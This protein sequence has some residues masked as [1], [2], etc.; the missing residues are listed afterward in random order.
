MVLDVAHRQVNQL[1][2]PG[3][4]FVQHRDERPIT[5]IPT[6]IFERVDVLSGQ[7]LLRQRP[8]LVRRRRRDPLDR[9]RI[10]I[11]RVIEPL[12]ELFDDL[13]IVRLRNLRENP[14]VNPLEEILV[15]VPP[16]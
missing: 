15:V 13:P 10:F 1:A 9:L 2:N 6:G 16:G 8:R 5:R 3:S 12:V 11:V 7:E 14:I 4:G